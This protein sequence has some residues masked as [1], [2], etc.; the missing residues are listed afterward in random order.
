MR[1]VIVT[2]DSHLAG[3]VERARWTLQ[4]EMP[5]L[6]LTLYATAEWGDDETALE[7]CRQD[8]S[9]GDIIIVTMLFMEEQIEPIL[10][11]LQARHDHCD[12]YKRPAHT[13]VLPITNTGLGI[14]VD[15]DP[16]VRIW[17]GGMNLCTGC[18]AEWAHDQKARKACA[19]TSQ[20]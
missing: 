16:S 18:L 2:L 15:R 1:V 6:S 20:S 12:G 19:T 3:A 4:K 11:W 10:P 8:I 13:S 5:G 9:E 17:G 14:P 7:R